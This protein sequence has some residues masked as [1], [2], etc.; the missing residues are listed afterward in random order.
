MV[1]C[2]VCRDHQPQDHMCFIKPLKCANEGDDP[3][4]DEEEVGGARHRKKKTAQLYIF[5][6]SE[7]MLVDK[8]H[9]PNLYVIHKVCADCI[10][11]PMVADCSCKR[12]QV[13]LRG[14]DTL[15]QVGKWLFSG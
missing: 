15:K 9:V 8:Q 7:C 5:Y 6:D 4:E 14:V 2:K 1:F 10:K 11:K 3:M 12:E 13:I